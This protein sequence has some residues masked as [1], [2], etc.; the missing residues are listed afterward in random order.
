MSLN[1]AEPQ[2]Q[3]LIMP[4]MLLCPQQQLAVS[5][6]AVSAPTASSVSYSAITSPLTE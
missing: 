4:E 6:A 2:Q 5:S 1:F 3:L